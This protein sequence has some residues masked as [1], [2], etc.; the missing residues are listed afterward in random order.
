MKTTKSGISVALALASLLLAHAPAGAAGGAG[1][2]DRPPP[3][4]ANPGG[5]VVGPFEPVGPNGPDGSGAPPDARIPISRLPFAISSPGSYVV[6]ANLTGKA[7]QNG[8]EVYTDD[9]TIDLNGF[10]LIGVAGSKAGIR[11]F[12]NGLLG[13]RENLRVLNGTVRNWSIFGIDVGGIRNAEL[14]ELRVARNGGGVRTGASAVIENVTARDNGGIGI[15]S[16]ARTSVRDVRVERN[17]GDGIVLGEGSTVVS[18]LAGE[19]ARGIVVDFGSTISGANASDNR[20]D[21]VVAGGSV[22]VDTTVLQNGRYGVLADDGTH[23]RS[24]MANQNGASGFL[25]SNFSSV[26]DSTANYN[27][28]SGVELQIGGLARQNRVAMNDFG[29]RVTSGSARVEGNHVNSN[30]TGIRVE[31]AAISAIVVQ[32][33]LRSN[34]VNLSGDAHYGD[35]TEGPLYRPCAEGEVC[36]SASAPAWANFSLE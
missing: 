28:Q 33:S 19:N 20:G 22:V 1:P 29:I 17:A 23:V 14:E 2:I 36:S 16:G 34:V 12:G 30:E 11:G 26:S 9:V 4:G 3:T 32:N 15:E 27:T 7:G 13:P 24:S 25:V 8:I 31:A 5:P 6:T 35:V 10:A 18:A 21:G